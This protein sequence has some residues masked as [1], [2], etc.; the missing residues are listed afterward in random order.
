MNK[1][2]KNNEMKVK[3][4]KETIQ[5]LLNCLKSTI[6]YRNKTHNNKINSQ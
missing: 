4:K 6:K 1:E 5:I 2:K 3:Q